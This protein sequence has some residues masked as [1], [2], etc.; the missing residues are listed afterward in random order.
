M[1]E[2][3]QETG[4][5]DSGNISIAEDS[6]S[7]C[8]ICLNDE[9]FIQLALR[10]VL[11]FADEVVIVDGG[12]T[13]KTLEKIDQLRDSRIVVFH[14]KWEG[15]FGKQ[16]NY[17]L[18]HATGK[19]ILQM[20]SDEVLCDSAARH[21]RKA[22]RENRDF[23]GSPGMECRI[24]V[25][26][27]H[28]RME[29]FIRDFGHVDAMHKIHWC[30]VRFFKN[31]KELYY[32]QRI[33]EVVKGYRDR[34]HVMGLPEECVS[35]HLGYLRGIFSIVEKYK[36]NV[37]EDSFNPGFLAEWK[38][39]HL[40]GAYPTRKFDLKDLDSEILKEAFLL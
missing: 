27:F 18:R 5:G 14:K 25:P 34:G 10:S 4:G 31:T 33:H 37:V 38:R 24:P 7:V 6:I 21:F 26:A 35:Y 1:S 20:D 17:A 40:M 22:A 19:W 12:S 2:H 30:Q 9:D 23:F 32:D 39:H 3:F 13:D 15:D 29:H 36:M 16:R 28:L 8:M 11:T